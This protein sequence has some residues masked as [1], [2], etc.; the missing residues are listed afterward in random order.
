MAR[1]EASGIGRT[2]YRAA[3]A[4]RAPHDMDHLVIVLLHYLLVVKAR[5]KPDVSHDSRIVLA[6][7]RLAVP[8]CQLRRWDRLAQEHEGIS[9]RRYGRRDSTYF[10]N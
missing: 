5:L 6:V 3:E 4:Q 1:F 10:A 8:A 7:L 9:G 2:W